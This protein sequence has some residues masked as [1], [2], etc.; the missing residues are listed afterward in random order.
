MTYQFSSTTKEKA[1][2]YVRASETIKSVSTRA[3]SC[4]VSLP[5]YLLSSSLTSSKSSSPL[6]YNARISFLSLSLK[7]EKTTGKAWKR[8]T[9]ASVTKSGSRTASRGSSVKELQRYEPPGTSFGSKGTDGVSKTAWKKK[10]RAH[11]ELI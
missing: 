1:R 5:V 10:L 8:Q 7:Y 6:W 3:F 9:G 2:E 11:V 4:H